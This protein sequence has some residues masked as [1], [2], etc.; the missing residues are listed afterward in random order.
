MFCLG[1]N[2]NYELLQKDDIPGRATLVNSRYIGNKNISDTLHEI[3]DTEFV[4]AHEQ[5]IK[6]TME[7]ELEQFNQKIGSPRFKPKQT[8]ILYEK[9]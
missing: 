7:N 3:D 4:T 1:T 2:N 5:P 6:D 9:V 8:D